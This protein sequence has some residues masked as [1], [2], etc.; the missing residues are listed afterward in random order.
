MDVPQ[1]PSVA[2]TAPTPPS[3]EQFMSFMMQQMM[4]LQQR[5][6]ERDC[7][8]RSSSPAELSAYNMNRNLMEGRIFTEVPS[9]VI[10][11]T[12]E[13]WLGVL[14]QVSDKKTLTQTDALQVA[15]AAFAYKEP[16]NLKVINCFYDMVMK[17]RE[18]SASHYKTLLN[19]FMAAEDPASFWE[20]VEIDKA[21]AVQ[22]RPFRVPGWRGS[23]DRERRGSRERENPEAKRS[24]KGTKKE[25][26]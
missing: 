16:A 18:A 24:F 23:F 26:E 22:V 5:M 4:R 21:A 17:L 6:D 20:H 25:K 15:F 1:P 8:S 7:R 9:A 3:G 10:P 14:H 19:A 13:D 2:V 11:R 12:S